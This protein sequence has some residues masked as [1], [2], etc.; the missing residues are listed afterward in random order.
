MYR[1]LQLLM[2]ALSYILHYAP[3]LK[4]VICQRRRCPGAMPLSF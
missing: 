3:R 4:I 1:G 2:Y